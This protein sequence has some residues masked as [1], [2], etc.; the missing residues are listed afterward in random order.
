[1]VTLHEI[2]TGQKEIAGRPGWNPPEAE[3]GYVWFSV[4]LLIGGIVEAGLTLQGG[5]YIDRPDV[6]VSFELRLRRPP[7]TR[8]PGALVRLDWR[9]ITGGHTVPRRKGMPRAGRS[10][11]STHLHPFSENYLP[12]KDQMRRENL[13]VA[14]DIIE[15]LQSFEDVLTL[16]GDVFN[17]TNI[18]VVQRPDWRYFL[19]HENS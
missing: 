14:I 12:D 9:S 5:C 19:F 7:M 16:C 2:A 10:T 3:T 15:H 18:G 8:K 17:I 1:M 11:K 4:P 6:H 13:P